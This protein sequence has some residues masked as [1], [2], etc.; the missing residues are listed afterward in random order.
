MAI[1]I[2]YNTHTKHST[3]YRRLSNGIIILVYGAIISLKQ[4]W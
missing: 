3:P 1:I 2:V 4:K